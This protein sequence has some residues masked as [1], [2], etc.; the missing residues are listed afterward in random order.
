VVCALAR[1]Q[2]PM[3]MVL[4]ST[5]TSLFDMTRALHIPVPRFMLRDEFDSLG[6]LRGFARPVLIMHGARDGLVPFTHG[7]RLVQAC[8]DGRL[9][10]FDE[11]GHNDLP[12][13]SERYWAAVRGLLERAAHATPGP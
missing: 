2:P 9:L 8:Q 13:Q 3:G 6:W 10:V 7:R 12:W 11:A 4:E 5:F 1:Q